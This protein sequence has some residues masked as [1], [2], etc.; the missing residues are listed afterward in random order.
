MLHPPEEQP[1]LFQYVAQ[2]RD[3]FHA[4]Q[5]AAYLPVGLRGADVHAFAIEEV[6]AHF[7]S[8]VEP[9][10]EVA[11]GIGRVAFVQ[12]LVDEGHGPALVEVEA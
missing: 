11:G 12:V 3:G 10:G 1:R 4:R 9:F 7:L 2:H 5:A 8:L 6:H